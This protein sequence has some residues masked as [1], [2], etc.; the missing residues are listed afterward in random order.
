MAA[1]FRRDSDEDPRSSSNRDHHTNHIIQDGFTPYP[2]GPEFQTQ[3]TGVQRSNSYLQGEAALSALSE[4]RS[5]AVSPLSSYVGSHTENYQPY[6]DHTASYGLVDTGAASHQKETGYTQADPYQ[7][8]H[9][10]DRILPHPIGLDHDGSGGGGG[11]GATAAAFAP[12]LG[13][14]GEQDRQFR[15]QVFRRW[16]WEIFS[17]ALALAM[18]IAIIVLLVVYQGQRMPD[19]GESLNLNT[20]LALLSTFLRGLLVIVMAEVLSQAKWSWFGA[21]RTRPLRNLADFDAA[22]RGVWGALCLVPTAFRGADFV[23][24]LAALLLV[25]SFGIGPT[26]QQAMRS[27]NCQ[28]VVPGASASIPYAHYV[29][30]SGGFVRGYPGLRGS[31]DSDTTVAV[32]S[33]LNSPDGVENLVTASCSTGNCTFSGGDPLPSSVSSRKIRRDDDDDD[34]DDE[35]DDVNYDGGSFDQQQNTSYSSIGLCHR[36]MNVSSLATVL[37]T[38]GTTTYFGLPNGLNISHG[39]YGTEMNA[40]TAD[41]DLSWAGALAADFAIASRWSLANITMLTTTTDGCDVS[42]SEPVCPAIKGAAEDGGSVSI[43]AASCILYP[44]LRTYVASIV[45]GMLIEEEIDAEGTGT[46][47]AV[48]AT[49]DLGSNGTFTESVDTTLKQLQSSAG[50]LNLDYHYTAIQAPCRAD[51]TTYATEDDITAAAASL[52]NATRLTLFEGRADGSSGYRNVSAPEACVY[53]HNAEFAYAVSTELRAAFEGAC[54]VDPR[55]GTSCARRDPVQQ[56]YKPLES[57]YASGNATVGTVD[58]YF[59]SVARALTSR[60]RMTYGSSVFNDSGD[61]T[62]SGA[63]YSGLEQTALPLGTAQGVAWRTTVC[64]VVHWEWLSFSAALVFLTT[65]LLAL[66]IAKNWRERHVRPV[67]KNSLLPLLF[68]GDRFGLLRHPQEPVP[69]A[70]QSMLAKETMTTNVYDNNVNSNSNSNDGDGNHTQLMESAQMKEQASK[71]MT[72]FQWPESNMRQRP[73]GGAAQATGAFS[74]KNVFGQ[75]RHRNGGRQLQQWDEDSLEQ[76]Q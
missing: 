34:S 27:A 32:S 75:G 15:Y 47:S 58:A 2:S 57:L 51:G 38:K 7:I 19:W 59:G 56:F 76:R 9:D 25:V 23:S 65:V 68:Y 11:G 74:L 37:S 31:P 46:G 40:T 26:V 62:G 72:T 33:S 42:G 70:S 64:T 18:L 14:P 39:S 45:N 16:G 20:I 43:R 21:G 13:P 4:A 12:P 49:P 52:S 35:D 55:Y 10:N 69:T 22:S 53:R 1:L 54:A 17:L 61:S 8:Q 36:C 29:P 48:A 24:I 5:E 63:V 60:Y 71:I 67:W 73:E 6:A 66:T 30:R 41:A 3:E 50:S 28:V 44:C